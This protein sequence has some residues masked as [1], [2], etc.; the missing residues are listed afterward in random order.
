MSRKIEQFVNALFQLNGDKLTFQT[1]T[2]VAILVNGH[3]EVILDKQVKTR[4]IDRLI[5]PSIDP[6][7]IDDFQKIGEFRYEYSAQAGAVNVHSVREADKLTVEITRKISNEFNI[8]RTLTS[9]ALSRPAK[10]PR[11]ENKE[12]KNVQNDDESIA[13]PKQFISTNE[14]PPIDKVL[15]TL[16]SCGGSDLHL[17]ADQKPMV[18]KDGEI[19][20]LPGGHSVLDSAQIEEW[21][22]QVASKRVREQFRNTHDAD[23]AYEIVELSRFRMNLFVDRNGTG[24]VI[25]T[26]PSKILSFDQLGLPSV[27]RSFCELPKGLVLVTGPTGSGKSTTLA[28]MI[29]LINRNRN[30]HII[31]IEDPIEFVHQSQSCLINQREVHTHTESFSRALR[32]ALRE[33]PDIVLVGEMRDLET[34]HIALETAETGHLVFGTLHTNTAASTIDRIIDQFPTDRQAQIRVM[35]SESLKGVIAQTLCKKIGGGRVACHE[36][37]VVNSAVANL[38]REGKTFQITSM[39]QSGKGVGMQTNLE[40][41]MQLVRGSQVSPTEAYRRAIDQAALKQALERE[42]LFI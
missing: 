2:S 32:A 20:E 3:R 36:I 16:I 22:L 11:L 21:M 5:I 1:G 4:Q 7:N 31:T 12:V 13:V 15:R 42:G 8:P 34:V 18:R 41:M 23:F 24:A 17:T 30:E 39:M 38:I 26:I 37:L 27:I 29:D 35:L 10:R 40:A 19:T 14:Q 9:G 6:E 28:A 25:R 33:D